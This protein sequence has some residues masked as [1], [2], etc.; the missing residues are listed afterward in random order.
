MFL[1]FSVFCL[2][3]YPFSFSFFVSCYL[4]FSFRC[5]S[6]WFACSLIFPLFF[7]CVSLLLFLLVFRVFFS[8]VFCFPFL[9]SAPKNNKK[10]VKIV[11]QNRPKSSDGGSSNHVFR[12]KSL[13]KFVF[14]AL[15]A[16]HRFSFSVSLCLCVSVSLC[17]CVSV[18]LCLC[19]SV[20]LCLC[21]SVSL[22]LC[23]SVS[24]SLCLSVSLSLC[25][26]VSLSLCLFFFFPFFFSFSF[27]FDVSSLFCVFLLLVFSFVPF[28]VF[29]FFS[30][31]F[32]APK[33]IKKSCKCC[34]S[35]FVFPFFAT[36]NRSNSIDFGRRGETGFRHM[37][38]FSCLCRTPDVLLTDPGHTP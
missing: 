33:I 4:S 14:V 22:S 23:L 2:F 17:L 34:C 24:L 13:S 29:C 30:V 12:H 31:R 26:S 38:F 36:Q 27:S 18:S 10:A 15:W 35:F 7:S 21:L 1:F 37:F 8:F 16:C 19:V 20:S 28:L 9:L 11:G 6:S 32:R 3:F 25:L 5:F